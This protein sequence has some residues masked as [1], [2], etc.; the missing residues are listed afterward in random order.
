MGKYGVCEQEVDDL[1]HG[2][3]FVDLYRVVRQGVMI[4]EPSYSLK[5]VEHLYRGRRQGDVASA[6]RGTAD[7]DILGA[8]VASQQRLEPGQ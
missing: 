4:G 7:H 3:V 6:G 2:Q 5:Y 1:L 8:A